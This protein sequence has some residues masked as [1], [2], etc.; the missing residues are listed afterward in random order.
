MPFE[1]PKHPLSDRRNP[2]KDQDGR[3]PFA[4]AAPVPPPSDNPYAA[5]V[6]SSGVSYQPSQHQISYAHRGPLVYWFGL[7]GLVTS[8]AGAAGVATATVGAVGGTASTALPLSG[9]LALLG[10]VFCWS[11]WWMSGHDLRDMQAGAMRLEGQPQT[12]RGHR[13]A[14]IG[15]LITLATFVSL[16]LLLAWLITAEM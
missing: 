8:L 3:N 15:L 1:Y 14:G 6:D 9:G 7:I 11:A 2:F 5:S 12:R 4:D 10:A 16:L 13:L